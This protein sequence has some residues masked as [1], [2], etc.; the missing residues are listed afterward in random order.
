MTAAATQA[1][2][3]T[4]V[5]SPLAALQSM[6]NAMASQ[7]SYIFFNQ[8]PTA[9]PSV[10]SQWGPNKQI[11]VDLSAVSNNGFPVTYSIKTQPK[12]GT[13]SFDASTGRY[14]YTP[15]ADFVTPGISDTFTITIN[16]GA[17]AALPGFA[18][19]VQGVVHSLAVALNIAKPDSIDQQI[20]VTV[21]GTGVYGGDVAQLAELHRQQNYWNCVL[22]SSAM[23]A[24]QV[25]NTL[26]EDEDTVVAW[27][28]ELDSIV[29]PGRKMFLSERLE[30]GAW[31]KDAVRLLEQH[32]AVTAVNT[33]YATY[34]ANG[35]RIAGATAADGQRALN[36]LDAALAQGS[37]ITV[38]I[39]NNALYS[40]VPGW[41]PGSANPNFTTYNHQIQ[42]LRVDVAN[43]KVW[44]NDSALPSGGTEFSLSAF[45]KSWQ[46]SDYDL[47]VVSAIPQAGSASASTAA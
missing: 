32:W 18:G 47:T 43:G 34:D 36:D 39:N 20:N 17:S 7:L 23:A 5:V 25:T 33:T 30:M 37:A 28:K 10:W 4:A 26:T 31:P 14:T 42:V 16:N 9:A 24:A 40:S 19:F 3:S 38:G 29:S 12:Y 2:V 21:T 44:V 8:A 6:W 35:K 45:M 13:L 46:A 1:A 41:K 22:M 27:A 11:T 15:N